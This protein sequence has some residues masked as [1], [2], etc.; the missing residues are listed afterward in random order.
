MT[1]LYVPRHKCTCHFV[2]PHALEGA[3]RAGV[4]EA[5]IALLSGSQARAK[6][7]SMIEKLDVEQFAT[8]VTTAA[9]ENDPN[10]T[11]G[12]GIS[13]REALRDAPDGAGIVFDPAIFK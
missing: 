11:L 12:S 5:R 4:D 13:L 3:A 6:R 9:D 8:V 7:A 1:G 10:G 2:T